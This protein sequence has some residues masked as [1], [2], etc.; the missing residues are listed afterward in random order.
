ML[1]YYTT[2]LKMGNGIINL[3]WIDLIELEQQ[4][5]NDKELGINVV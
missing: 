1:P 5:L 2:P 3:F 4:A